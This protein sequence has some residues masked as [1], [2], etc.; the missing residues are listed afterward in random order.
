MKMKRF[1][2][3]ISCVC[4][5]AAITVPA[6]AK[7]I[8]GT[9]TSL[10]DKAHAYEVLPGTVEWNELE[11]GERYAVCA[12]SEAEVQNMTTRALVETV[13]NYPYLI[14]IYAYDSLTLGIEEVSE[15]FPGLQEL[16]NRNDAIEVLEE[17]LAGRVNAQSTG[18]V[19]LTSYDAQT[20]I[21]FISMK[22]AQ[23]KDV[24]TAKVVYDTVLTPNGSEVDV[25]VDMSWSEVS[26]H[27]LIWP[28]V[29]FDTAL[30]QSERMEDLYPSATL[31]R[32]PAP[33]YNCHSYA[34]YSTS[35][36]NKYWM[37][38][39]SLYIA[40]GSYKSHVAA[41][42]CTLCYKFWLLWNYGGATSRK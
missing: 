21:G 35:S 41:V 2:K 29:N 28:A 9:A 40:D 18:E 4:L 5:V 12:V 15:Y 10:S 16:L 26:D 30:A 25:I 24:S 38:D 27:L 22:Q 3:V 37:D 11:P 20:L 14:N 8:Y 39:P 7:E 6:Y 13:L 1:A 33:N 31:Y 34:W 42:G 17:F 32:D 36:S 23:P 19:D